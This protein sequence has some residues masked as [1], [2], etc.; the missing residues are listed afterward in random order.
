MATRRTRDHA[1]DIGLMLDSAEE[2]IDE[3]ELQMALEFL[4]NMPKTMEV[5]KYMNDEQK[6]TY[7]FLT[8]KCHAKLHHHQEAMA[9]LKQLAT[10]PSATDEL[11]EDE[12]FTE[13]A[14]SNRK[15]F[16]N[17]ACTLR[18]VKRAPPEYEL[19]LKKNEIAILSSVFDEY[20]TE[21]EGDMTV[22]EFHNMMDTIGVENLL[23]QLGWKS[24]KAV[25]QIF[26][27]IKTIETEYNG[28]VTLEQ[29]L[30]LM[31]TLL[32]SETQNIGSSAARREK[33]AR[34]SGPAVWDMFSK[35]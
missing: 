25:P 5:Q 12:D 4:L 30:N 33:N 7:S 34:K 23:F 6:A 9:A 14:T 27:I 31:S 10:C 19:K 26:T 11:I 8:A 3:G 20:D 32:P 29:Y 18:N 13:L 28:T 16:Q 22:D 15:Q 21:G 1:A 2:M 17:I 24:P 35:P